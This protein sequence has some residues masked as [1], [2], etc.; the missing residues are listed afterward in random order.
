MTMVVPSPLQRQS[1]WSLTAPMDDWSRMTGALT[2]WHSPW[3]TPWSARLFHACSTQPTQPLQSHHCP[4][5][6]N[7]TQTPP[8]Y[9]L[10][11]FSQQLHLCVWTRHFY[12]FVLVFV[13][14]GFLVWKRKVT[15]KL[16]LWLLGIHLCPPEP[17]P[18]QSKARLLAGK[19]QPICCCSAAT[20]LPLPLQ[21]QPALLFISAIWMHIAQAFILKGN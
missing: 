11:I 16:T 13:I 10:N 12:S 2:G 1:L 15:N 17:L 7:L 21:L 6:H 8:M 9:N 20:D 4:L 19:R 14:F 5:V 3:M 18:L